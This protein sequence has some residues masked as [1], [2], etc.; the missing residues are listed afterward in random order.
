MNNLILE[1]G[2]N[3]DYI[4][5]TIIA[6]FYVPSDGMS[7]IINMDTNNSSTYYIQEFIKSK[8]IYPMHRNMSIESATVNK[9]RLFMYN[10]GWLKNDNTVHNVDSADSP[11]SPDVN[12][13][14]EVLKILK[15]V[16]ID[17][18][19]SFL[20]S[21]MM[22]YNVQFVK[23]DPVS[24]IPKDLKYNMIKI[25]DRELFDNS[26]NN[27]NDNRDN[28]DNRDDSSKV[29]KLTTLI[30]RWI[31]HEITDDD[32]SY[33]FDCLPYMIPVYLDIRDPN[34]GLNKKYI[35]I[36]EGINFSNNGDKIQRMFIWEIHS[37]ICQTDKGTFYTV[38]IDNNDELIAF[39]D[40]CIPSNWKID[41]SSVTSVK[42]LMRE[43]RFVFY[44][45]Q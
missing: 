29:V 13:C 14:K 35:D 9:L 21:N 36:M 22:D 31:G 38:I 7:K 23:I 16:D 33:K 39:S 17:K 34:T 41:S 8:F 11:S 2:Y 20:I 18:F 37:F 43:V 24:N 19:Y 27:E 12:G 10:C 25:T 30:D 5:S 15:R 45:L 40:K 26:N 32:C 4:Y 44:R 28:H 3:T 1:D 6:L 42:K